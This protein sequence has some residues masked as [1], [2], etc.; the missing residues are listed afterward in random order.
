MVTAASEEEACR[1]VTTAML[2]VP[3]LVVHDVRPGPY[4]PVVDSDDAEEERFDSF[5]GRL[6]ESSAREVWR[7]LESHIRLERSLDRNPAEPP[8]A[9]FPNLN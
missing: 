3:G 1:A 7:R 4:E 6:D 2:S 5:L 8:P 9:Y